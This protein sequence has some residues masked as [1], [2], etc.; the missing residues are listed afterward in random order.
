MDALASHEKAGSIAARVL[1]EGKRLAKPGMGLL[2]LAQALEAKTVELGAQPAFP[3]NLS[4][5]DAAAHYTPP[6]NDETAIGEK[7]ILKIDVGAHVGGF[8]GDTAATVDFSGE[9]GKLVEASQRGL[10]AALA[11]IRAGANTKDVGSAVQEAIA[12]YGFKPISNLTGHSLA[13]YDLHAGTEVPNVKTPYGKELKEGDVL[14]VEPFASTGAG[15]VVD[16][17]VVEIF[18]LSSHKPVRQRESRRLLFHVD[19]TYKTLPFAE[20]W[21]AREFRSQLLLHSALRELLS[22]GVLHDYPV[23]K[24]AKGGLVSQAELTVVV[25][26]DSCRVLTKA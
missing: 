20:R 24:D 18:S 1:E 14:A 16:G 9:N 12:A 25:E 15:V 13:Q 17:S 3:V 23:L 19:S 6:L 7:D 21:L 22:A 11:C 10:D 4:L 26:K 2:E 5:N 8:I